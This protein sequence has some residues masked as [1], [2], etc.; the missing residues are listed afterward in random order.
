MILIDM[1]MPENCLECPLT[2]L[3]WSNLFCGVLNKSVGES[4]RYP[5]HTETWMKD[6]LD[7]KR[8]P[9]C[10]LKEAE[11]PWLDLQ[12]KLERWMAEKRIKWYTVDDECLDTDD[13]TREV[14]G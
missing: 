6:G 2:Q 11:D 13:I 7:E 4:Y 9:D 1:P 5:T 8:H 12:K 10:P 3:R 14:E